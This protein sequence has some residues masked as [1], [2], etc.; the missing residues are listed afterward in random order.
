[1]NL[2]FNVFPNYVGGYFVSHTTHKLTVTPQSSYPK[3]LPQLRKLPEYFTGRNAFHYLYY[4]GRKIAGRHLNEYFHMVFHNFHRIYPEPI[5]FA[6]LTQYCL[7]IIRVL[8]VNYVL[9][10]LRYPYHLVFHIIYG[11]LGP[12]YPHATAILNPIRLLQL[13]LT[14]LPASHFH[15][16]S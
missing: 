3:L 9:P 8:F 1:M 16:T 7:S 4:P 5:F 11:M 10:V 14:R 13:S 6:N 15:P 2:I 12:P